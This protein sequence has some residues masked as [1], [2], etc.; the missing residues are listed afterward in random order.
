[1]EEVG[2]KKIDGRCWCLKLNW[3]PFYVQLTIY[4]FS[5]DFCEIGPAP[6]LPERN[7]CLNLGEGV[8]FIAVEQ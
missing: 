2:E 1:M 7:Y 8:Y 6:E 5:I 3:T 4:A